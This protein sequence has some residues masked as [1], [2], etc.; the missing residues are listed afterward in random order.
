LFAEVSSPSIAAVPSAEASPGGNGDG[1]RRLQLMVRAVLFIPWV[2][3][4]EMQQQHKNKQKK[5]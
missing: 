2:P 4:A 5:K 1:V 3:A